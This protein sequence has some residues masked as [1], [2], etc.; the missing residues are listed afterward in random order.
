MNKNLKNGITG[1]LGILGIMLSIYVFPGIIAFAQAFLTCFLG[2][3]GVLLLLK[4]FVD[5]R[6]EGF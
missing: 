2:V 6:K 4:A 3:S 1:S 5:T